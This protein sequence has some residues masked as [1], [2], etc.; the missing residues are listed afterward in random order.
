M[1]IQNALTFI[2]YSYGSL[3]AILIHAFGKLVIYFQR[4]FR[5]HKKHEAS[6][7]NNDE[8][9][10]IMSYITMNFPRM[11]TLHINILD[12]CFLR[13]VTVFNK[14]N[15]LGKIGIIHRY[16]LV[17]SGFLGNEAVSTALCVSYGHSFLENGVRFFLLNIDKL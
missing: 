10:H 14:T 15:S 1:K 11:C 7:L 17:G 9:L 8:R 3:A 4:K 6:L 12:I 16:F 13:A 2:T 5:T